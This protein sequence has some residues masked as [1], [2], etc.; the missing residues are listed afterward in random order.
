M[1]LPSHACDVR[2]SSTGLEPA[3]NDVPLASSWRDQMRVGTDLGT[4]SLFQSRYG[5]PSSSTNGCGAVEPFGSLSHHTGA[6]VSSVNGPSGLDAVATDRQNRS[7]SRA[8][9]AA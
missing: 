6:D 2:S 7:R 8:T 5:V 3:A 9:R 4:P 1:T